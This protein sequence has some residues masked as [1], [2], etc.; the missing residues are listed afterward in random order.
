[1]AAEDRQ[2]AADIRVA[3]VRAVGLLAVPDELLEVRLAAH[4]HVLVDR[5]R[6][7]SLTPRDT[8]A[9]PGI[10]YGTGAANVRHHH[11]HR[12]RR[13]GRLGDQRSPPRA[14]HRAARGRRRARPPLRPGHGDR[15]RGRVDRAGPVGGARQRHDAARRARPA[16]PAL[17]RPSAPDARQ[18]PRP[19]AAGRR[20]RRRDGGD[21][22]R[23]ASARR[24]SRRRS[25]SSRSRSPTTRERST[26]RAPS[27]PRTTSSPSIAPRR[28]SSRT[29]ERRRRRSCRSCGGRSRTA[30]S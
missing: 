23:R 26:T 3:A 21:G 5:H 24:G 20:V 25:A 1:M 2:L 27:S 18:G 11:R 15:G 7:V 19:R 16:R 22:R 4:A 13:Q 12:R 8:I 9:V 17:Q 14:R 10:R 29:P 28:S 6:L 30:S